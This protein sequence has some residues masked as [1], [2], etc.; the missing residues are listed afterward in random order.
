MTQQREELVEE[1][2]LDLR[3]HLIG[4]ATDFAYDRISEKVLVKRLV[5]AISQ[6]IAEGMSLPG[7]EERGVMFYATE[8]RQIEVKGAKEWLVGW[9]DKMYCQK[10]A[11]ILI[12]LSPAERKEG[13]GK[14]EG[15]DAE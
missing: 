6:A 1:I 14:E 4:I 11:K 13:I 8:G 15:G 12:A 7:E 10:G 5:R 9:L 2:P 3:F